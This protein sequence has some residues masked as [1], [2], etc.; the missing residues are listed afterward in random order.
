MHEPWQK[1]Q[2]EIQICHFTATWLVQAADP[3]YL[4]SEEE[5]EVYNSFENAAAVY[6]GVAVGRNPMG[7]SWTDNYEEAFWF[8]HRFDIAGE[9][10]YVQKTQV[11]RDKMLAYFLRRGEYELVVDTK[12]I[13]ITGYFAS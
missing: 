1:T 10:G 4:M 9:S 2:I 6:S 13:E 5:R 12:G 3:M 8:A 11:P 7:L